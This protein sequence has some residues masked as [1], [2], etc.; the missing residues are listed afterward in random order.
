[1]Q[2]PIPRKHKEFDRSLV[3][4]HAILGCR[5]LLVLVFNPSNCYTNDDEQIYQRS[6]TS[7]HGYLCQKPEQAN[8]VHVLP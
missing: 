6:L 8:W 2:G 4:D 5:V 3:E 1:M 7:T